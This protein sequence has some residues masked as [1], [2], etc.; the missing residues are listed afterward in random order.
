MC[1]ILTPLFSKTFIASVQIWLTSPGVPSIVYS[2]GIPAILPEIS[3]FKLSKYFGIFTLALVLS[4][5]SNPAI[6]SIKRAAI[7]SSVF[8]GVADVILLNALF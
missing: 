8:L 2:F 6:V 3:S 7:Y 1:L 4:L 5:L